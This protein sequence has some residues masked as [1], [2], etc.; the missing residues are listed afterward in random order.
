MKIQLCIFKRH[1]HDEW[2]RGVAFLE[3][4][5]LSAAFIIDTKGKQIPPKQMWDYNLCQPTQQSTMMLDLEL[6]GLPRKFRGLHSV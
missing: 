6:V 4:D 5:D 1:S 2:E 3:K